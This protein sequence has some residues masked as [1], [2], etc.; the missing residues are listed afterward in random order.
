VVSLIQK[1]G[2]INTKKNTKK[3]VSLI[4]FVYNDGGQG[5][6]RVCEVHEVK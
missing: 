5:G 3:I 6:A 2:F 1:N 4:S